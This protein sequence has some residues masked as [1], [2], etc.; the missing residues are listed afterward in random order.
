MPLKILNEYT[1][2]NFNITEYTKDG[3]TISHEVKI[4]IPIVGEELPIQEPI[5]VKLERIEQQRQADNLTQ[6]DV[7]ATIYEELLMKS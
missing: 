1:L 5:H 6:F 7:L 3:I 2:N 4:P